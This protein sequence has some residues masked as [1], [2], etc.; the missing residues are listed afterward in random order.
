MGR[1]DCPCGFPPSWGMPWGEWHARHAEAHV[2]AFPDV[3][4]GTRRNLAEL[5]KEYES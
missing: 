3:D 5:V 1:A 4:K 2:A